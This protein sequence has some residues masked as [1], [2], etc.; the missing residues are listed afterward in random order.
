MPE[1]KPGESK[2]DY[3]SRC[4]A[5]C[6]KNEGLTQEQAAGKCYGMWKEQHNQHDYQALRSP[7]PVKGESIDK[8]MER[9]KP[10]VGGLGYS[11]QMQDYCCL[12]SWDCWMNDEEPPL[13]PPGDQGGDG[14]VRD[15][16][17]EYPWPK[18]PLGPTSDE[19]RISQS[20]D[21]RIR[22][23]YMF[24][25]DCDHAI[26]FIDDKT[27][28]LKDKDTDPNKFNAVAIKGDCFYKGKFLSFAEIEKAHKTMDGA[29]H[30]INHWGTSYPI[31]G[32][33]N[34]EYI[35]GYQKNTVIDPIHKTMKTDIIVNPD[36]PHYKAWKN[37]VD[38]NK[39]TGRRPN[40]SVSFWADNK[41]IK[42]RD[43]P[44]GTNYN[45]EGYKEDSDVPVLTNLSFQ[46]LSTVFKG[47]CDD[48]QGCGIGLNDTIVSKNNDR[49][50]LELMIEIE[51]NKIGGK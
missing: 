36:A 45:M 22:Q 48:K 31:D 29:Y 44:M 47:A 6:I 51:K 23:L 19:G 11:P 9:C 4:I 42:A 7:R 37:F 17:P 49:E 38:I 28:E 27:I 35:I 14:Q 25:M 20:D 16:K 24:D 10:L 50:K 12:V 41:T 34:I 2:D 18:I 1:K 5:Y 15:G 33:P 21:R 43:L 40:V 13:L 39:Q 26:A 32:H 30:D 3:I 8:F 46:A